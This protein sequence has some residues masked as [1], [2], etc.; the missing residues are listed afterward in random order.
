MN[1]LCL[2]EAFSCGSICLRLCHKLTQGEP[3]LQQVVIRSAS[4]VSALCLMGIFM[5]PRTVF[6]AHQTFVY[7]CCI[8]SGM[9]MISVSL[10]HN[11]TAAGI[12]PY[13]IGTWITMVYFNQSYIGFTFIIGEIMFIE[14]FIFFL[15]AAL[16]PRVSTPENFSFVKW[17]AFATAPVFVMW[18]IQEE[19][20]E[21]TTH[22]QNEIYAGSTLG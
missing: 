5:I 21:H 2:V 11:V 3:L 7:G 19:M 20:I 13:L 14:S 10:L 12:V 17:V 8:S 18:R 6:D 15:T 16:Y 22:V 4:T 1:I 9:L